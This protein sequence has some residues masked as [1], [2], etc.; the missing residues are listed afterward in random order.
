MIL[1]IDENLSPRLVDIAYENVRCIHVNQLKPTRNA[2][3]K[4]DLL[5]KLSLNYSF[6]L[7]TKD[8]DF[9]KSW[10]SRKVPEKL[11]FIHDDFL[12]MGDLIDSYKK[13]IPLLV[14]LILAYDFIEFSNKGI[15]LPFEQLLPYD[16]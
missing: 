11:I 7:V 9:V 1:L 10:V 12:S 16:S 8:N 6:V 5:R 4:D 3:I 14:P 15:R 13:Q 2:V